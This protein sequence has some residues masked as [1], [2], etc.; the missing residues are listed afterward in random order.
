MKNVHPG[1]EGRLRLRWRTPQRAQEAGRGVA[2]RGGPGTSALHLLGLWAAVCVLTVAAYQSVI[3]AVLDG[4]PMWSAGLGPGYFAANVAAVFA[5]TALGHSLLGRWLPA[6][7]LAHGCITILVLAHLGKMLALNRPLYLTDLASAGQVVSLLPS[8]V[9]TFPGL[10][11]AL[12]MVVL[13]IAL[14]LVLAFRHPVRKA[15]LRERLLAGAFA[16]LAIAPLAAW[17]HL[18][19]RGSNLDTTLRDQLWGGRDYFVQKGF[20]LASLLQLS[21]RTPSPEVYDEASVE[22]ALRRAGLAP[23]AG[24]ALPGPLPDIVL[25]LGEAVWDPTVLPVRFDRDPAPHLRR[26]LAGPVAGDMRVPVFGGLTPQTELEVLTG[27]STDFFPMGTVVFQRYLHQPVPALPAYLRQLG[28]HTTAVHTNHGWFWDR[29][30]VFPLLGFE[31]FVTLRDFDRPPMA[32]AFVSDVALVDRVVRECE[33][34]SPCFVFAIS[35]A[36]HGPYDRLLPA[37]Q[38]VRVVSDLGR[39]PRTALEGY[40]TTLAH[41]D[42]ALGRLVDRLGSWPRPVVVAGFG[43]HL[44]LLGPGF[45][46]YR[47]TGFRSPR[48]TPEEQERMHTTPVFVWSNRPLP[49]ERLHCRA[50]ALGANV[51]RAAGLPLPLALAFAD[52]VDT[53]APT[54]AA[55]PGKLQDDWWLLHHD[56]VFGSQYLAALDPLLGPAWRRLALLS[57]DHELGSAGRPTIEIADFAPRKLRVGEEHLPQPDGSSAMWVRSRNA[58]GQAQIVLDG[59]PLSTHV[60][61]DGLLTAAIPPRV[62]RSAGRY[63]VAVADPV[64]R[65]RS[66]EVELEVVDPALSPEPA[67]TELPQV[68]PRLAEWGPTSV[69]EG[70]PFNQ[71]PDGSSAFWFRIENPPASVAVSL[72]GARIPS[73]TGAGG[74]VSATT[75]SLAS[76][77]HRLTLIDT[78][79]GQTLAEVWIEVRQRPTTR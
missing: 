77:R 30:R 63:S 24:P 53:V 55:V 57:A 7:V 14:G 28:Y 49:P 26:L 44:P 2:G 62:L 10:L 27:L 74:M 18:I 11:A 40:A 43:D 5:L 36:S 45:R 65:S 39:A 69:D 41:A 1:K 71:Q 33:A 42:L 50:S 64:T 67:A 70:V 59:V 34:A 35:M 68:A 54:P 22:A 17:T 75:Q 31:R 78:V 37:D 15:R 51:L 21:L 52:H 9:R 60:G 19:P 4:L 3:F 76:G 72:D 47:E 56:L 48:A 29:A 16:T 23:R 38:P 73:A 32:G 58:S 13:A 20:V 66:A 46:V 61:P 6:Q 12:A 8:L 25:Y 79:T